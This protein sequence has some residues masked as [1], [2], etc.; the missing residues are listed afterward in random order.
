M[1]RDPYEIERSSRLT[2]YMACLSMEGL[3]SKVR[4][5]NLDSAVSWLRYCSYHRSQAYQHRFAKDSVYRHVR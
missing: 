2:F 4:R 3:P 5:L 1:D